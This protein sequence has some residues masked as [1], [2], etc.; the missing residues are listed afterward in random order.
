MGGQLLGR[1]GRHAMHDLSSRY[2]ESTQ[3]EIMSQIQTQ[4]IQE[5]RKQIDEDEYEPPSIWKYPP[6]EEEIEEE[7]ERRRFQ[8]EQDQKR[9]N[10]DHQPESL[11]N[12]E[13]TSEQLLE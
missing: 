5:N 13:H 10:K 4:L 8:R 3:F 2:L 12:Q 6:L 7:L 9:K 11:Q 1:L